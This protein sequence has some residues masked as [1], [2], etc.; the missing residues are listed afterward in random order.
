MSRQKHGKYAELMVA[1]EFIKAGISV[2]F[3]FV[4]DEKVDLIIRVRKRRRIEHYDVQVKSVRGYNRVIGVDWKHIKSNPSNY[5][6]A[7][8]FIHDK[9]PDEIFVLT[10]EDLGKLTP[11]RLPK[12]GDLRFTKAERTKY[13]KRRIQNIDSFL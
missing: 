1:S 8:A 4:D 6:L 12:W 13:R 9:K 5:L 2:F 11:R 3:P 7:V 10:M